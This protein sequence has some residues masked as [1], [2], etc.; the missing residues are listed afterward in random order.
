MRLNSIYKTANNMIT[1]SRASELIA[2]NLAGANQPGFKSRHQ[3]SPFSLHF[4]EA[5]TKDK[6]PYIAHNM[7]QGSLQNTGRPLDVAISGDGFFTVQTQQ[8]QLLLT[9]NG[10]FQMNQDRELTTS[11]GFKV[12]DDGNNPITLPV[13]ATIDDLNISGEGKVFVT[14]ATGQ[15]IQ[16]ATLGINQMANEQERMERLSANYFIVKDEGQ[17]AEAE[18]FQTVNRMLEASNANPIREMVAMISNTREFEMGQKILKMFDE[19]NSREQQR[20]TL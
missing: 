5:L 18:G 10:S 7:S 8:E 6:L 11:E 19:I 15:D 14:D 3:V 1:N 9:R 20:L 4:N 16:I 12:M 17:L 2:T 13:N